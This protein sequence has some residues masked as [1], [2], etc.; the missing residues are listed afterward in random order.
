M[1]YACELIKGNNTI[2]SRRE[3]FRRISQQWYW[4]L[5]FVLTCP[6]DLSH[7][8]TKQKRLF[9]KDKINKVQV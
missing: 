3:R 7:S 6:A 8:W 2:I 9:V 4:F 5:E 1:I